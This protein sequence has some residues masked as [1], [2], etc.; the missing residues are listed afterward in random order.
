MPGSLEM[1]SD[2]RD[3]STKDTSLSIE[4]IRPSQLLVSLRRL[5]YVVLTRTIYCAVLAPMNIGASVQGR[6]G[7]V[8]DAAA[9]LTSLQDGHGNTIETR[10]LHSS[11]ALCPAIERVGSSN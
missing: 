9:S 10:R 11:L 2:D 6:I 4:L 8:P 7:L 3:Q 1:S 5:L